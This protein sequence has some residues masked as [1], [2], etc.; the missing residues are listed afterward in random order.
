MATDGEER[1]AEYKGEKSTACRPQAGRLAWFLLFRKNHD[2]VVLRSLCPDMWRMGQVTK[3][4][5][6]KKLQKG[7]DKNVVY[8]SKIDAVLFRH[9]VAR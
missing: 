9:D 5:D 8:V 7:R 2:K 6:I 1:A 3:V 4:N